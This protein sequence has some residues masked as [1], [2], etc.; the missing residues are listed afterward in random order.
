[1]E[2]CIRDR[3]ESG[4]L[5]C[6]E[7]TDAHEGTAEV[8]LLGFELCVICQAAPRAPPADAGKGTGRVLAHRGGLDDFFDG[9][10]GER[11]TVLRDAGFNRIPDEATRHED[12]LPLIRVGESV[13]SVGHGFDAEPHSASCGAFSNEPSIAVR[14]AYPRHGAQNWPHIRGLY[15]ILHQQLF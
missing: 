11:R 4:D 12:R 2:M 1:M 7:F 9:G 5:I 10:A 3:H 6:R 13:R 8:F 14:G 15:T